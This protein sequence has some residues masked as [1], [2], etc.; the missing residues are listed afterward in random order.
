[1][2]F[3]WLLSKDKSARF[4]KEAGTGTSLPPPSSP[5]PPQGTSSEVSQRREK[6]PACLIQAMLLHIHV[7][8]SNGEGS[9]KESKS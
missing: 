2:N 5:D 1:M 3:A 6:M 8:I 4:L 9:V 7:W